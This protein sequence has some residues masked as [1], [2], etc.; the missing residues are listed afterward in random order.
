[1]PCHYNL[2]EYLSTYLDGARLRDDSKGPLFRTIGWVLLAKLGE[3]AVAELALVDEI[4][5]RP[6]GELDPIRTAGKARRTGSGAA[7][8]SGAD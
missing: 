7:R 3:L 4:A 1:M 8:T 6:V 2:E 5:K